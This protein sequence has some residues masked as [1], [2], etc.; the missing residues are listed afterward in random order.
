MK[1]SKKQTQKPNSKQTNPQEPSRESSLKQIKMDDP[2]LTGR[3]GTGKTVIS[4]SFFQETFGSKAPNSVE[5][6]WN[7]VLK[8]N[9]AYP[10]YAIFLGLPSDRELIKYLSDFHQELNLISGDNCL[11]LA[12]ANTKF[13][14]SGTDDKAWREAVIQ[15]ITGD[16]SVQLAQFLGLDFTHLPCLLLLKSFR[17]SNHVIL[18]LKNMSAEAISVRMRAVFS[19]IQNSVRANKNPIRAIT[20][21][22]DREKRKKAGK[23]IIGEVKN[24]VGKAYKT[25]MEEWIKT[26][27]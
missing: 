13:Y 12:I 18:T 10:C 2:I 16:S 7:H 4:Y 3:W 22:K 11:I 26:Q 8:N 23:S 14:F 27:I 6:W 19:I 5:K 20:K 9:R 17:S 24:F 21:H 25:A 1:E 15:H